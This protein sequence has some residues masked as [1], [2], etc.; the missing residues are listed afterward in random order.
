MVFRE[1]DEFQLFRR[2]KGNAL[3]E[4]QIQIQAGRLEMQNSRRKKINL[5]DQKTFKETG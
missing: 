1:R 2:V 3:F 5:R 4:C